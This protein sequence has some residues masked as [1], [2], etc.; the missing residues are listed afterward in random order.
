[1]V[2]RE[3][4]DLRM[5]WVWEAPVPSP[6]STKPL[7]YNSIARPPKK[8]RQNGTLR[9]AVESSEGGLEESGDAH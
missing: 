2:P 5:V 9:R 8:G 1:M 4:V 3:S 7:A 6:S